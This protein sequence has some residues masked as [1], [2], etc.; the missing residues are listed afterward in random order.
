MLLIQRPFSRHFL[1]INRA[2]I[3]PLFVLAGILSGCTKEDMGNPQMTIQQPD[4]NTVFMS[5]Q[6][7]PFQALFTDDLQLLKYTV[8]IQYKNLPH[9]AKTLHPIQ[10]F[11]FS[12]DF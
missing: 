10:S 1:L 6:S 4:T 9:T 5:G 3:V 2:L 11:T 12:K 8:T 7:I